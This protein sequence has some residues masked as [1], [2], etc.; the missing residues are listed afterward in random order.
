MKS[1]SFPIAALLC[2]GVGFLLH[3]WQLA[4]SFDD[5]GLPLYGLP[6]MA[7]IVGVVALVDFLAVLALRSRWDKQDLSA[8]LS[9]ASPTAKIA[10]RLTAIPYLAAA[11]ML[12]L[13]LQ[14]QGYTSSSVLEA[15]NIV[16]PILLVFCSL[17]CALCVLFLPDWTGKG[18]VALTPAVPCLTACL[19]LIH[20]YHSHAN[21]PVLLHYVWLVLA[22]MASMLAWRYT[23]SLAFS[24][25]R[26]TWALLWSMVT[27]ALCLTAMADPAAGYHLPFLL[28]QVWWFTWQTWL[29][30]QRCLPLSKTTSHPLRKFS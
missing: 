4:T 22:A 15:A 10:L 19:W 11:L 29:I 2:G 13:H 7:L 28:A 16:L 6:T 20:S 24:K 21:D 8:V 26:S 27:V 1:I 3:R 25:P 9:Q 23:C 14:N 5:Q 17:L 18:L 30:A 12:V